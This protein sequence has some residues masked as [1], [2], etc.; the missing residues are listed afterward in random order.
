[1]SNE[2]AS[3][4]PTVKM[5]AP[6]MPTNMATNVIATIGAQ[7][8]GWAMAL[9]VTVFLPRYLGPDDVGKIAAA[10]NFISIFSILVPL[11]TS[12]VIVQAIARDHSRMPEMVMTALFLRVP[13]AIFCVAISLPIAKMV[14]LSETIQMLILVTSSGI[15][16]NTIYQI[17]NSAL[18]GQEKLPLL[19]FAMLVERF[20]NAALT[21]A[22]VAFKAPLW[23]FAL[24]TIVSLLTCVLVQTWIFRDLRHS[25][26]IP[27]W[28]DIKNLVVAG[29]P[30]LGWVALTQLYDPTDYMILTKLTNDTNSGWYSVSTRLV[31]TLMFFPVAIQTALYPTLVRLHESGDTKSFYNL[32]RRML[33]IIVLFSVL[34]GVTLMAGGETIN[35]L[36]YGPK[37]AGAEMAIRVAGFNSLLYAIMCLLGGIVMAINQQQRMLNVTI[38]AWMIGV[39]FCIVFT[40][41]SFRWFGNG[42]AGAMASDAIREIVVLIGMFAILPKGLFG[43]DNLWRMIRC[44]VAALPLPAL[45]ILASQQQAGIGVILLALTAGV[46]IYGGL[47]VALRV[48]SR[49]DIVMVKQ[50]V[51]AKFSG[52]ANAKQ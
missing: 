24:T 28:L 21:L 19:N 50:I 18:Q 31:G 29:I 52:S 2:I 17:F 22:L 42:A 34:G 13:L 7:I 43:M 41:F 44:I 30:F 6:T 40:Y 3:P 16:I 15:V 36:V 38:V 10:T 11:G 48:V 37:Y 45:L 35:L 1:M 20:A 12:T 25:V 5:N 33:D 9:L 23:A 49:E 14:G 46:L 39:A 8:I 26:Y 32:C 27:A 4:S 47:C 51:G